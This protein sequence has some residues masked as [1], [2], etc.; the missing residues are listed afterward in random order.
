MENTWHIWLAAVVTGTS[1]HTIMEPGNILIKLWRLDRTLQSGIV[2]KLPIQGINSRLKAY[3]FGIAVISFLILISFALVNW[4]N[5]SP[6]GAIQ[7]SIVTAIA[8]ELILMMRVDRYHVDIERITQEQASKKPA[9][10][11]AKKRRR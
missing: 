6:L 9:K 1:L 11:S 7:Y 10:K 8:A 5:P 4:V 2:P 3:S